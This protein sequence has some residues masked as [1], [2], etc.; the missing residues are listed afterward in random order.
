[1]H[2]EESYLSEEQKTEI[3]R[4]LERIESGEAKLYDWEDVKR[5]V[6]SSLEKI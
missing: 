1:M 5:E 2:F 4:R 6:K 3:D